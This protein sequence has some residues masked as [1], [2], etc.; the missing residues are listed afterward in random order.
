[1]LVVFFSNYIF[2]IEEIC[3]QFL[4]LG[5]GKVKGNLPQGKKIGFS[6]WAV[7][8]T[9]GAIFLSIFLGLEETF[10]LY[11]IQISATSCWERILWF[12]FEV[13]LT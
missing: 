9:G 5:G 12:Q 6:K 7:V 1:M 13:H 2:S 10:I 3:L 4:E 11:W 8:E